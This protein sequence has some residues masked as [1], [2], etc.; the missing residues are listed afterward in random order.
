MTPSVTLILLCDRC[1]YPTRIE[2]DDG[3]VDDRVGVNNH[4]PNG[5]SLVGKRCRPGTIEDVKE[6]Q[7]RRY[8]AG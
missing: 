8:I 6:L 5:C 7:A 1:E 3:Y 2:F 4:N